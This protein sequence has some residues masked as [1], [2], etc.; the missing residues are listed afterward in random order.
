MLSYF[1]CRHRLE[2]LSLTNL[3]NTSLAHSIPPSL[4]YIG[5]KVIN[6]NI[7]TNSSKENKPYF[8]AFF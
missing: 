6:S 8:I 2:I 3:I 4:T 1:V 7:I 5:F